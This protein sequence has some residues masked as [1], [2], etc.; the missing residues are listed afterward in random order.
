M[1]IYNYIKSKKIIYYIK[2]I[3]QLL[4]NFYHCFLEKI[5]FEIIFNN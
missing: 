5:Y 3:I 4:N 1:N 2:Y